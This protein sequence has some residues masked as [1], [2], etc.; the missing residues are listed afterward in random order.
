MLAGNAYN[1]RHSTNFQ[2]KI[3]SWY[4]WRIAHSVRKYAIPLPW[5]G[6]DFLF[7]VSNK[8]EFLCLKL[9]LM[10]QVPTFLFKTCRKK[11]IS[12]SQ[13]RSESRN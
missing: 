3:V 13:D 9:T 8:G 10:T 5:N 2:K 12:N 11:D 6:M 1:P 7:S 4:S